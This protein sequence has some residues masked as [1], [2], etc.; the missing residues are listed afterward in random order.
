LQKQKQEKGQKAKYC[1]LPESNPDQEFKHEIQL[2]SISD[3]SLSRLTTYQSGFLIIQGVLDQMWIVWI[4]KWIMNCWMMKY[5]NTGP[6]MN[7]SNENTVR[8]NEN[9]RNGRAHLGQW[10]SASFLG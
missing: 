8:G 7:E 10:Q 1:T 9:G 2:L 3:K 5:Q 6:R 4:S